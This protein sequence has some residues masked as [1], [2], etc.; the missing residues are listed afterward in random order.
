MAIRLPTYE[1]HVQLDS[2][3]HTIARIHA[4][5]ATGKAISK[6]GES[7]MGVAAHWKAKQ[8]Q[9][10]KFNYAEQL[11]ILNTELVTIARQVQSEY[12]PGKH[13]PGW[14]HEQIVLRSQGAIA[15][16]V[17]NAPDSLKDRAMAH[18]KTLSVQTDHGAAKLESDTDKRHYDGQ[19]DK[20]VSGFKAS[21]AL[22]PDAFHDAVKQY[23][24]MLASTS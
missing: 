21:L 8:D 1:S 7:I 14:M 3:A 4:D 6:I 9:Y 13:P 15:N 10:D 2:G 12:E 19:L 18:G 16:W 23:D 11:T 5:D 20:L 22:N 24:E 17:R